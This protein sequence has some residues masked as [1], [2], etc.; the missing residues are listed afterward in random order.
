MAKLRA[1]REIQYPTLPLY[2]PASSDPLNS[3]L[4]N[5]VVPRRAPLTVDRV[6]LVD[7]SWAQV[8][9]GAD[10]EPGWQMSWTNVAEILLTGSRKADE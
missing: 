3:T 9:L 6:Q 8:P 10:G 1:F 4:R 7:V 2:G 5:Q